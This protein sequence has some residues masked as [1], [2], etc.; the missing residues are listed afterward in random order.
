MKKVLSIA[1]SAFM[2]ALSIVSVSGAT[3]DSNVTDTSE[4]FTIVDKD[5][6]PNDTLK[7]YKYGSIDTSTRIKIVDNANSNALNIYPSSIFNVMDNIPLSSTAGYKLWLYVD[8]SG[9]NYNRDV[10]FNKT[11]GTYE[12]IRIKLSEVSSFFNEDGTHTQTLDGDT[13]NYKF[14]NENNVYRSSLLFISG[15]ALTFAVP[16]ENGC[17]EIYAG[18]NLGD[19]IEYMAMLS[20]NVGSTSGSGGISGSTLNGFRI[21]DVN[22]TDNISIIDATAIQRYLA[23]KEVFDSIQ[24]RSADANNDGFVNVL[25]ATAI[26][27]YLVEE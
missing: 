14:T 25:D 7:M 11:G 22:K 15:S 17:V 18:T 26:Q 5:I 1:L 12:K 20:S 8:G 9:G 3:T 27:K 4:S 6:I 13:H 2:V 23:D 10:C 16:D 24:Q 19:R 21:G